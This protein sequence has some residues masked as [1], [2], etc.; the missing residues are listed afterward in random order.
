MTTGSFK[1]KMQ[2]IHTI[3]AEVET[4]QGNKSC[5]VVFNNLNRVK[6]R[7]LM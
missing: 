4:G 2:Q 6:E 5:Q 3:Y 7:G 1:K